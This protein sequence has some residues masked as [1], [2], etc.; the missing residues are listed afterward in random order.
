VKIHIE[1]IDVKLLIIEASDPED[2]FDET[3]DGPVT[4]HL[5]KLLQIDSLLVYALDEDHLEKAIALAAK[6]HYNA[7]HLSCH[8]DE[9]GIAVTDCTNIDW[10]DFVQLFNSQKYSPEALIMSSCH[11]AGDGLA[12]EFTKVRLRPKIIFGSRDKRNY[13]EYAVAW[14][15]LYRLFATK[16]IDRKVGQRALRAICS[17]AHKNF[18]YL[19]W[20]DN[21]K[22]YVQFPGE[23]RRYEIVEK[24]KKSRSKSNPFLALGPT[25]GV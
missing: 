7:I 22:E 17:V 3:L 25:R 15:I 12:D 14:T 20:H 24:K 1:A 4:Y 18:R 10:P 5:A 13:I 23:G 2:F 21:K 8:G 11:G 6:H 19:R 9:D 16:G